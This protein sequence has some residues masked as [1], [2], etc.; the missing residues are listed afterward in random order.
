ML[1]WFYALR[2]TP[3]EKQ[4]LEFEAKYPDAVLFIECG[5][6]Y[7]LFGKDAEVNSILYFPLVWF[8]PCLT[9]GFSNKYNQNLN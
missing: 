7:R 2:Y 3:L 4:Y 6:K 5:Y 8:V 9:A 1:I